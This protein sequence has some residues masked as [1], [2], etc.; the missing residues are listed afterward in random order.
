MKRITSVGNSSRKVDHGIVVRTLMLHN[1]VVVRHIDD[2][3][4]RSVPRIKKDK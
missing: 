1:F 3:S 2:K 4:M